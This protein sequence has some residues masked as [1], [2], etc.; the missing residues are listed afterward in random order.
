MSQT[1]GKKICVL[2]DDVEFTS[3]AQRY[4]TSVGHDVVSYTSPRDFLADPKALTAD[5]YLIDLMLPDFDGIDIVSLIRANGD[6]GV[7]VIS[8]KMGP[9]AFT[10]ALAAG[11]DMFINK[12]VRADQIAQAILSL[13]RRLSISDRTSDGWILDRDRNILKAPTGETIRLGKLEQRILSALAKAGAD[14]HERSALAKLI[15]IAPSADDRNLDAA[16]FR[17][18]RKIEASTGLPAPILT[19][20]GKGYGFS[21]PLNVIGRA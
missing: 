18:R 14:G 16:I 17:L 5:I 19:R 6:A 13:G 10:S 15:E 9:D 4:L 8:G 12:P 7:I 1:S 20:H 21:G 2:D 3:F 11:A